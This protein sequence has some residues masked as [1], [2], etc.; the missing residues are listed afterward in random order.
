[1]TEIYKT[2]PSLVP[3]PRG[4]GKCSGSGG[5][6]FLCDFKEMDHGDPDPAK[7][8]KCISALHRE[9]MGKSPTGKFGTG[10]VPYDGKLPLL[11]EWD[12]SWLSYFTKLMRLSYQHARD[13]AI[14]SQGHEQQQEEE[15]LDALMGVVVGRLIPRLLGPLEGTIQ[16]CLIHGDLWEAN[17]GTDKDSG[18]MYI[19][20]AAA[21]WA[22]SEKELGIWRCE[23][24]ETMNREEYLTQYFAHRGQRDEPVEEFRDR[25]LLYSV[26]TKLMQCGHKPERTEVRSQLVGDLRYLV[27]KYVDANPAS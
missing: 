5:F 4:Y 18:E 6:Y 21:Y 27:E 16:P 15:E 10:T 3:Q 9:S 20:D 13:A 14:H 2:M 25:Q 12:D 8:G 24:H 17:T 1:M 19:F 7:L 11:G 26:Q 23:H 22:H